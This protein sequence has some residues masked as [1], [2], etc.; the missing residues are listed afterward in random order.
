AGMGGKGYLR[1]VPGAAIGHEEFG[2]LQT[3]AAVLRALGRE[4][5]ADAAMDKALALPGTKSQE[6]YSYGMLL[7]PKRA[8]KAMEVFQLNRRLTPRRSS[9]LS[10]AWLAPT[11]PPETS[12]TPSRTGRS[13]L[14]TYRRISRRIFLSSTP[15]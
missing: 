6:I 14:Q 10:W 9:G 1:A 7:L 5:E 12:P 3:K 4:S 11:R 15:P 8:P 13:S 2:T